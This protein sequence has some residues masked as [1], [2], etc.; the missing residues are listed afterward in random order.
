MVHAR[1]LLLAVLALGASAVR[2]EVCQLSIEANDLMQYD[3]KRLEVSPDC[4]EVALTL[5]HVGKQPARVMGHNWVLARSGDVAAVVAA[6]QNAGRNHDYQAPGD[7][8]IVA[9]TKVIGGG[10]ATTITFSATTLRF[11]EAYTYFCS[12][13]GHGTIM[14]GTLVFGDPNSRR[15]AGVTERR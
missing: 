3:K 2:A 4:A 12:T 11:G 14:R 13:P 10:E 6:G 9:A 15:I 1:V 7:N 8:R 5:T